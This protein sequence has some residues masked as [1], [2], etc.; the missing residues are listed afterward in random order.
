MRD[1]RI[2]AF[3]AVGLILVL[4]LEIVAVAE[5]PPGR[6]LARAH[7]GADPG[8][9]HCRRVLA[10][11]FPAGA[12]RRLRARRS[13]PSVAPWPRRSRWRRRA[14]RGGHA[15]ALPASAALVAPALA[16]AFAVAWFSEPAARRPHRRRARRDG[17][18]GRAGRAFSR[19]LGVAEPAG[20]DLPAAARRG[21]GRRARAA[22]SV[23]ST[24]RCRRR[25]SG[26]A[27]RRRTR[28]RDGGAR[29]RC[30]R[31]ISA[32]ARRSAE[33]IGAP[34]GLAP[35]HRPGAAR[36]V[37]GALGRAHR[38]RRSA[39]ASPRRS[40]TGWRASASFRFPR[41][42]ACRICSRARGPAF[43][44]DRRRPRRAGRSR[45]SRTAGTNR[46]LL[47]RA[48][49]LPLGAAPRVRAGLRGADASSKAS[50]GGWALRRLNERPML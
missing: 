6:A 50:S 49:G 35:D 31:A 25:A 19:V 16:V 34:H 26:S 9:G 43:D 37:H 10:R 36:D 39:S 33:I 11:C 42:R 46:A 5:L 44:V 4:L 30:S 29:P 12:A 20:R 48:L 47:C 18:A 14:R 3:G 40:P 27:R 21:R 17:R 24:C 41:A 7:R 23:T 1:S 22:S 2:G 28:L 15:A 45:S 38:R 13:S 8:P 32:R